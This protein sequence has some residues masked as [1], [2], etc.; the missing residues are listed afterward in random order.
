MFMKNVWELNGANVPTTSIPAINRTIT[1]F[2]KSEKIL[3]IHHITAIAGHAQRNYDLLFG[4]R[5][6]KKT[7]NFDDPANDL[8]SFLL[9][10]NFPVPCR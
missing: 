1:I 7:V 6:V 8:G 10:K 9:F 2:F 5:F 4:L 3:G